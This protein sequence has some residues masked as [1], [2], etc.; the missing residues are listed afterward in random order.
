MKSKLLVLGASSYVGKLL[1]REFDESE[2]YCTYNKHIINNG[3]SFNVAEDE[4]SN[5]PIDFSLVSH[6]VILLGDTEPN[7]CFFDLK[8]SNRLNIDSIVKIINFLK[9]NNI[10]IVFC[11]TEFIY[12]GLKGLYSELD[13]PNPILEYGRQKLAVEKHLVDYPYATIFRFAKIYGS[14]LRDG[15]LFSDWCCKIIN[16]E[17]IECAN[18][19]FF[20]PVFV[21]DVIQAIRIAVK[22]NIY[23]VFNLSCGR[24]YSRLELLKLLIKYKFSGIDV[25][26]VEKS[27]DDFNL[28]E[29]RPKDVSMISEKAQTYFGINFIGPEDFLHNHLTLAS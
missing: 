9:K 22:D 7:S 15:T 24:R 29:L 19:Q 17:T 2:T 8:Y 13:P 10:N 27:I 20:S 5:L 4:I 16:K 25:A 3:I 18:D 21:G 11:S 6:A 28:P 26:I 23:G 14:D 12:D 1:R